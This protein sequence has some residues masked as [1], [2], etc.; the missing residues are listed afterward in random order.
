MSCVLPQLIVLLTLS[1]AMIAQK[2]ST[3]PTF[4]KE[5]TLL[6]GALTGDF[7]SF[8]ILILGD[9]RIVSFDTVVDSSLPSRS[10]ADFRLTGALATPVK[11]NKHQFK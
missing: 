2:S 5:M 9:K 6:D 10:N 1:N 11:R 8:V 4:V 7:V 3:S